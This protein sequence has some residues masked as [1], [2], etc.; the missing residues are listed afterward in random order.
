MEKVSMDI[1]LIKT[2]VRD[3]FEDGDE[4]KPNQ[5]LAENMLLQQQKFI[6]IFPVLDINDFIYSG[7]VQNMKEMKHLVCKSFST[8][9]CKAKLYN[10]ES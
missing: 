9:P 6:Q 10:T 4:T 8:N 7:E 3:S 5:M 2:C 1:M